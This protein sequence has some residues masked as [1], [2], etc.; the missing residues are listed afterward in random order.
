MKSKL[1]VGVSSELYRGLVLMVEKNW[2]GP[3]HCF[4]LYLCLSIS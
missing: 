4:T 2:A 1:E 3:R